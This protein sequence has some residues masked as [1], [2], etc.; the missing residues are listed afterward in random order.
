MQVK[1]NENKEN[2]W[3][4]KE[5]IVP[6]L[7]MLALTAVGIAVFMFTI[8]LGA[9]IAPVNQIADEMTKPTSG[10][11]CYVI[12][13][14]IAFIICAILAEKF[15]KEG[16]L[17]PAF[18]TGFLAG[19]L[20]WQSIGEGSWHFG[21]TLE[22]TY[23]NFFRIESAG[24][25]LLAISFGLLTAY[26]MKNRCLGFGVLCTVLS[27]LCNWY[28]HFVSEGTYPLVANSLSV[29]TWYATIGLSVG[30]IISVAAVILAIKKFKDTRG[31]LLCSML[32]Y[33]GI[34]I[35]SFGFIE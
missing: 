6:F 7:I 13:S 23:L 2:K 10:R 14:M 8:S 31:H 29:S 34:S 5:F 30:T 24:S 12:F 16:K 27:F 3:V 28:G 11:L 15:S 1:N 21:Y 9:E 22:G 20:L 35:I 33:I 26:M 17:Y 32:L 4:M 18:Y 25:L 19:M